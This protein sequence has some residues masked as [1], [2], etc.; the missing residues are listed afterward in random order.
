MVNAARR[1]TYVFALHHSHGGC[2]I[3]ALFARVGGD[4]AAHRVP[5]IAVDA[6]FALLEVDGA[7]ERLPLIDVIKLGGSEGLTDKMKALVHIARTVRREPRDLTAADIAAAHDAGAVDAD[8][9][10]AVLI[11]SAFSM[12]NRMVEGFRARTLPSADA[13]RARASEIAAHGY[14]DQRVTSVPR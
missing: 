9:Q 14:S 10:L 11:A 4:V 7:P 3:L 5:V 8:V 2:P 13:Y 12:Y 6:S 1:P